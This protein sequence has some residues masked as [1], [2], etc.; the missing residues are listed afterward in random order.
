MAEA[1]D[2]SAH[3]LQP[4]LAGGG[5]LALEKI[6]LLLSEKRTLLSLL[7]TGLAILTLPLSVATVLVATSSHYRIENI[8]PLAIPL[9]AACAVLVVVGVAILVR[10]L[11][12]L[13]LIDQR[14]NA[15]KRES[16]PFADLIV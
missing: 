16:R 15:I 7:R 11:R 13:R 5:R 2:R 1:S 9:L 4:V 10:S 3:R 8:L 12:R 14:I 6:E